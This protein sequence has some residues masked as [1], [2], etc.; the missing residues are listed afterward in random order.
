MLSIQVKKL[1]LLQ[2]VSDW[3]VTQK[4]FLPGIYSDP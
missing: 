2:L 3:M 4:P 1:W